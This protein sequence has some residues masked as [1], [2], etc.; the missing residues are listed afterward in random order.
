MND[1]VILES[2]LEG[3]NEEGSLSKTKR[4]ARE[5]TR[6]GAVT[7]VK[8]DSRELWWAKKKENKRHE[9]WSRVE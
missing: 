6:V 4:E 3:K 8:I 9:V 2:R 7:W 1:K 5:D